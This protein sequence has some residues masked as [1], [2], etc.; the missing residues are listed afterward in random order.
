MSSAQLLDD[1]GDISDQV[2]L[3]PVFN[4]EINHDF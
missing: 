2:R 1:E 4:Q 3:I